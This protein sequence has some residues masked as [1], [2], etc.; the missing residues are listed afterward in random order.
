MPNTPIKLFLLT[1]LL[2]YTQTSDLETFYPTSLLE[3]GWDI[4]FFWVARMVMMGIKLTG[5]APFNEV[6]CH[7]MIRD[8]HGRKM[9]KSLGNVIDPVDVIQGI[10]L[11]ELHSKLYEGNLDQREIEKAK[12]GQKADFP[13]GI[14]ECGTDALRFALCAYTSGG[15]YVKLFV[16]NSFNMLN[17]I[18]T[19]MIFIGRDIN[20]DILRVEGYRKFC[21]KLWN[22]TRFAL[23]KLGDD[24]KPRENAKV[25][26]ILLFFFFSFKSKLIG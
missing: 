1:K 9:S 10:S 21:N 16:F 26:Y 23:L 4:L 12:A 15:N 5:Q 22:A 11:D 2:S 7:A 19:I 6:F 8:A 18:F 3:T 17:C 13:K 24:F 25:C 20:L 14:P